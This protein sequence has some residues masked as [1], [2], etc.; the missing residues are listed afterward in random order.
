[1]TSTVPFSGD[2]VHE[3]TPPTLENIVPTPRFRFRAATERDRKRYGH[4]LTSEGLRQFPDEIIRAEI[5]ATLQREWSEET[6]KTESARLLDIFERID[7]KLDV[8]DDEREAAA[9]LTMRCMDV[10]PMLRRMDADNRRFAEE[11]PMVALGMFLVGWTNM[12]TQ[13]RRE[14]GIVPTATL[15]LL[16]RDL[17]K[18]EQQ[19][20]EDNVEGVTAGLGFIQLCTHAFHLMLLDEDAEKNSSAPSR[21]SATRNGSKAS[22]RRDGASKRRSGGSR[23]RSSSRKTKTPETPS[24]SISAS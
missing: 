11:A 9:E 2:E 6:F 1:M 16:G 17:L 20:V 10:S 3:F 13:F 7:Q 24:P 12:P 22:N 14:A 21:S 18:I 5:L 19:A 8:S 15:D 4:L 23:G